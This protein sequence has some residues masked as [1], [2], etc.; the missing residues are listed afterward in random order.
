MARAFA[1]LLV[2]AALVLSASAAVA[3]R[4]L[5]IGVPPPPPRVEVIGVPPSPGHFWVA[6]HWRWDG[7]RHVW[8]GGHWMASRR[9][10]GR[11]SATTGRIA[12]AN[13]SSTPA[14]G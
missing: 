12:A 11:G 7:H 9:E 4:Q 13:G 5:R 8:V 14:A 6:G 2:L 1:R 10:S 3:E